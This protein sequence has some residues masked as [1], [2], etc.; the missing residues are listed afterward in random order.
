MPFR[1]TFE[2]KKEVIDFSIVSGESREAWEKFLTDLYLRGLKEED[3]EMIVT[4]GGKGLISALSLSLPFNSN[5]ALKRPIRQGT[6]P[7]MSARKTLKP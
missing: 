3:L 6:L 4:D 7:I 5:T 2:G 1:I